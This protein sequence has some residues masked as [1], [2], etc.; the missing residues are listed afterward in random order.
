MCTI[1]PASK[2]TDTLIQMIQAGMNVARLNFSHGTYG[3]HAQLIAKIRAAAAHCKEPVG[4]LA[5]LQGPRLR[6]GYIPDPGVEV[7][8]HE[9]VVFDTAAT[10][11]KG[12]GKP[13][14][15]IFPELT[16]WI[17]KEDRIL[18]DD[19]HVEVTVERIQKK[20]IKCKV[21]HGGVIKAH[22]GINTPDT[23]LKIASLT[24]KDKKDVAFLAKQG[25][26]WFGFSFVQTAR[27]VKELRALIARHTPKKE[28]VHTH[29]RILAK[30]ESYQ[31]VRNIEEIIGAA[32]GVMVARGDLGLELPAEEVPILQKRIVQMCVKAAKPVIVATQML[33]SMIHSPRP[34][35]AEVSDVANAVIDHTDA[36]MLS[37]ETAS[38]E[39]PL[40]AVKM[41]AR[42]CART[43]RS[44]FDDVSL[45]SLIAN[46]RPD[47]VFTKLA[48]I[49]AEEAKV[50]ALVASSLSGATGRQLSSFRSEIS[51]YVA[52]NNERVCRQ[53]NLSWGVR[54]FVV[55]KCETPDELARRSLEYLKAQ[56]IVKKGNRIVLLAG[57][58]VGKSGGINMMELKK[59]E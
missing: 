48:R 18:I 3:D 13:L 1:G 29:A 28:S 30:I 36:I 58:S 16:R 27:D 5:D 20:L 49:L 33:D 4:I 17:K 54:P 38:G 51:V 42:I 10:V 8:D 23:H 35:R 25:V 52:T 34:T 40:Q 7:K 43:E 59:V 12:R 26:D 41:M 6:M 53:L 57:S 32:D 11:Y 24:A 31:A 45:A 22:K 39:Y 2:E 55:K 19:G 14:P 21:V 47:G 9:E 50:T 56:K 37:G 15:L 46:N 44:H